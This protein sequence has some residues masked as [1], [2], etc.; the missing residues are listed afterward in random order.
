VARAIARAATDAGA[1]LLTNARVSEITVENGRATGVVLADGRTIAA[2][3]FVASSAPAPITMLE[4]TGPQH[5]DPGLRDELARYRWLEEA[6]FGVHWALGDRPR[7]TAE[8]Y[9]PDVPA[10]LNLALGYES[11]D[12]LVAHMEVVRADRQ[13]PDG[14]L[15]SSIPTMHDPGQ[16]PPGGHTTFGWH[17]VPG[18]PMRGRWDGRTV[19]QRFRAIVSTYGRYAPN[20][21]AVTLAATSHSPDSTEARVISMRSGD[22]HHGSFHPDNWQWNRP[23]AAMPGYRTPIEGLY[24][25]GSSQHPGGSFHGQPGHNAAGVIAEDVG[26]ERWWRPVDARTAFEGLE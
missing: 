21:D 7:F 9:N 3:K 11:S 24:L 5:L 25:C 23:T 6:L 26:A 22:R 16:A 2:T 13:T 19:D 4:L 18:P 12:D 14:P 8:M 15:H 17:F 20:L 1:I 10:A